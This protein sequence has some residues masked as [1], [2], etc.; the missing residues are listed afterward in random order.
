MNACVN[1]CMNVCA[2]VCVWSEHLFPPS[3]STSTLHSVI[4][5]S[6]ALTPHVVPVG[7]P[8]EVAWPRVGRNGTLGLGWPTKA[9][10][11][12]QRDWFRENK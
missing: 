7:L 9:S 4:S 1:A 8:V 5:W 10:V 12:R 3:S 2:C 6:A 11:C